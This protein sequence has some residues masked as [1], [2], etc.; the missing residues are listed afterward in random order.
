[1]PA[2]KRASYIQLVPATGWR[3]GPVP[4]LAPLALR[5]HLS[6]ALPF[7]SVI[8]SLYQITCNIFFRISQPFF[9][10]LY[11][12]FIYFLRNMF[13]SFNMTGTAAPAA[14]EQDGGIFCN[15]SLTYLVA[16]V[17]NLL[18]PHRGMGDREEIMFL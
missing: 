15:L 4:A 11:S 8:I 9:A 13:V 2:G 14:G 12:I 7:F 17:Y 16:G 18:I 6:V 1:L 10:Y 3:G 5:R